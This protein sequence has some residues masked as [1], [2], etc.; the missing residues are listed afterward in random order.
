[1]LAPAIPLVK[2]ER[3]PTPRDILVTGG[4]GY[5]GRLIIDRLLACPDVRTVVALD[6]KWHSSR[7][8]D[9]RLFGV[10][11]DVLQGVGDLLE[12]HRIDTLIHL[13]YPLEH[14]RHYDSI[15]P[16]SRDATLQLLDAAARI[17]L[18]KLVLFSSTTIY[19]GHAGRRRLWSEADRPRPNRGYHY[20]RGKVEMETIATRWAEAYP[21]TELVIVRPCIV[22]GPATDNYMVRGMVSPELHLRDHDPE[23][24]FLHEDDLA[25]AVDA[26]LRP[27]IRG[28]FNVTPDDPGVKRSDLLRLIGMEGGGSS[29]L[30]LKARLWW[31][32]WTQQ[33]SDSAI[34]PAVLG[35]LAYSWAASSAK[36]Y[37]ATGFRPRY[38]SEEAVL[39]YF[40]AY[41]SRRRRE[42][43]DS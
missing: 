1:M 37:R 3:S 24:Q 41:R 26:L 32:W 7:D 39:A 12:R 33:G 23:I 6:R 29:Y 36:L 25:L 22:L 18:R 15:R 4:A 11:R 8:V 38:G 10:E 31:R 20:A 2:A 9:E 16:F 14:Q 27:G 42:R 17:Q 30:T 43:H 13:A 19:G 28:T 35:L 34:S 40:R 21:S 5:L